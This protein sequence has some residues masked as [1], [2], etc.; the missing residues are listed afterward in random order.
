MHITFLIDFIQINDQNIVDYNTIVVIKCTTPVDTLKYVNWYIKKDS[1]IQRIT[2][3]TEATVTTT[4]TT[5][6]VSVTSATEVWKGKLLLF[7]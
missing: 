5:S 6:T 4:E 3:G 2:N 7:L 1:S